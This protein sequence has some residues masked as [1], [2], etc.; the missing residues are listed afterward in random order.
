MLDL[1]E[2]QIS[3]L[4]SQNWIP[5]WFTTFIMDSN[6]IIIMDYRIIAGNLHMLGCS[7]VIGWNFQRL[8]SLKSSIY[9]CLYMYDTEHADYHN[10]HD[11]VSKFEKRDNF[12]THFQYGQCKWTCRLCLKITILCLGSIAHCSRQEASC[13]F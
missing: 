3:L 4:P 5:W 10:D 1:Y 7:H 11:Y 12:A 6:C 8:P 13:S 9:I 2:L